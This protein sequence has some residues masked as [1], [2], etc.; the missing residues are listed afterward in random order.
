MSLC[1]RYLRISLS[2]VLFVLCFHFAQ[3]VKSINFTY[4]PNKT[5]YACTC[6]NCQN[7][8]NLSGCFYFPFC[9]FRIVIKSE[10]INKIF[11][12]F[13]DLTTVIYFIYIYIYFALINIEVS[14]IREGE[15]KYTHTTNVRVV[16]NIAKRIAIRNCYTSWN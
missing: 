9:W 13:K 5:M 3:V 4:W 16:D 1:D 8:N 12:F 11:C 15:K 10:P 14:I 6:C 7:Y 2:Y